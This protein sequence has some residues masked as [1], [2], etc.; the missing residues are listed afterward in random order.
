MRSQRSRPTWTWGVLAG[1][2]ACDGPTEPAPLDAGAAEV[3]APA[4]PDD[5]APEQW[6]DP[7]P[8]VSGQAWATAD[9]ADDPLADER[10]ATVDCP[11][12]T[13]GLEPSGLEVQTGACNYF[14]ATQPSLSAI[15]Q[16]DAIDVVVFHQDLDAAE[17]AEGHVALLVGDVVVWE[18]VVAIPADAAVLEAR[19]VAERAWPADTPVGLHLHNHGYNAWT[20]VDVALVPRQ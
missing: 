20:L 19:V 9:A 2:L 14:F 11:A 16:G 7:L 13:W 6:G 10:P 17:P 15:E 3:D 5:A 18:V 4:E 8:L 12:A 1:L